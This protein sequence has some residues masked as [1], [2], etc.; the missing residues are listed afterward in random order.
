VVE[1]SFPVPLRDKC[2]LAFVSQDPSGD[3]LH[4]QD[5]LL[6]HG[7]VRPAAEEV[8]LHVVDYH[9]SP[10]GRFVAYRVGDAAGNHQLRLWQGP[11]WHGERVLDLGAGTTVQH[12]S[13]SSNSSTLAVAYGTSAGTWLCGA[14]VSIGPDQS[15]D[16]G[17]Q[18]LHCPNPLEAPVQSEPV[19]FAADTHVAFHHRVSS[20]DERAIKYAAYG[21]SGFSAPLAPD[22]GFAW[23]DRSLLLLPSA[24]GF[25]A[26]EVASAYLN[27]YDLGTAGW[28][29][30]GNDAIAPSGAYTAHAN[31]GELQLFRALD[32][33]ESGSTPYARANG[34][35]AILAWSK[36]QER[37]ACVDDDQGSVQIHTLA[38]NELTT[39]ALE[40][41]DEFVRTTWRGSMRALSPS[42]KWLALTTPKDLYVASLERAIPKVL[43]KSRLPESDAAKRLA[44]SPD[45]QLLLLQSGRSL[46]A[47]TLES[48]NG[49][50]VELGRTLVAPEDCQDD[51]LPTADWCGNGG[52]PGGAVWSSDSQ[53]VAFLNEHEALV[54]RDLRIRPISLRSTTLEVHPQ[55]S[56]A[57]A[58]AFRFQ[59]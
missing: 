50:L 32:D 38:S 52:S 23:Y 36:H 21:P 53:L 24:T 9:F 42:G 7:M 44:F 15:T 41:S 28:I 3:R 13:W 25:F 31:G 48:A 16:S 20:G 49:E 2:W 10:D 59:P 34:C 17:A 19:W 47:F 22:F 45:E 43:W 29:A 27:Y 56:G 8:G 1:K 57:C 55:C 39:I 12:Y 18:A 40:G 5:P 58:S 51:E 14:E 37:I 6:R 54:V 46:R 4:L 33:S 11:D 35:S 26:D 30:H